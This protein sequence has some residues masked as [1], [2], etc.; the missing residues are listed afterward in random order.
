MCDKMT[1][2]VGSQLLLFLHFTWQPEGIGTG[3]LT[4]GV[5]FDNYIFLRLKVFY[6][7]CY[8]RYKVILNMQECFEYI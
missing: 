2:D 3:F 1:L 7:Q 4:L 6:R 8:Q 5:S